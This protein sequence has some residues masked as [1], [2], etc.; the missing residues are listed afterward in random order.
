MFNVQTGYAKTTF[1]CFQFIFMYFIQGFAAQ[2]VSVP[3]YP[4][5]SQ[6]SLSV[7]SDV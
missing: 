7:P 1:K 4:A 6:V 2:N 5:T 3:I